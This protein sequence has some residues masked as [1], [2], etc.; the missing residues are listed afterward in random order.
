M[1]STVEKQLQDVKQ[2]IIQGE[3]QKA[4]D[5]IEKNLKKKNL[6]KEDELRFLIHKIDVYLNLDYS[7]NDR[8]TLV[9]RIL[10]ESADS[11]SIIKVDALIQ[12]A[13]ALLFIERDYTKTIDIC[14]KG[15]GILQAIPSADISTKDFAELKAKLLFTKGHTLIGLGNFDQALDYAKKALSFAEESDNKQLI[16]RCIGIVGK[17]YSDF[18]FPKKAEKWMLQAIEIAEEIGNKRYLAWLFSQL[19]I[20][21]ATG[22]KEYKKSHK[23][24]EKA[25]SLAETSGSTNLIPTTKNLQG[26][27]YLEMLQLDNAID[28]FEEA[29]KGFGNLKFMVQGNIGHAYFLKNDYKNALEYFLKDFKGSEKTGNWYS[30]FNVL[31]LIILL[32]IELNDLP[33]AQ[34]YL[35]RFEQL[36]KETNS[37]Q[38]FLRHRFASALVLKASGEI[39]DLG[40]AVELLK[41]L[42]TED[43]LP[44]NMRLDALYALLEIRIKELQLSV[45]ENAL[46]EVKKQLVRLEVEANEQK[47]QWL[48]GNVYRLQAQLALVE[49]D[50]KE[51]QVL[52][53]KSQIIADENDIQALKKE[54]EKDHKKLNQQLVLLQ[55]LQEQKA[56]I[57]ET[58]KLTSLESAAKSIKQETVLEERDKE[59]GEIMQYRKLFALKI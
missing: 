13:Q 17:V 57:S 5:L 36:A 28:C 27:V 55:K 34:H 41:E 14:D 35:N 21:L 19:A 16:A 23:L 4:H 11:I 51:A 10:E 44:K 49:L 20:I 53:E 22:K 59:T 56:P 6:S 29:L 47:Y 18:N 8:L 46:T 15:L 40:Q 32:S 24:F 39:S 1:P 45:N 37:K 2:L 50:A 31:P 58:V 25:Y 38:A 43:E 9:E 33:Q 54:L 30:M 12:K 3:F 26:L 42:L 48:L 7:N 52:L